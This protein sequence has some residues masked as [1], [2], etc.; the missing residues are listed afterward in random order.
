MSRALALGLVAGLAACG[1][2]DIARPEDAPVATILTPSDG[3]LVPSGS[4]LLTGRVSDP[5]DP[6]DELFAVWSVGPSVD[7]PWTDVCSGLAGADGATS[8]LADVDA[9]VEALRLLV[10]DAA[11]FQ[12][13]SRQPIVVRAT[14]PPTV[15]L[16]APM[17]ADAPFPRNLP[18]P[19]VAQVSDPD[20]SLDELDIVWS[21]SGVGP[22]DGPELPDPSGRLEGET[23]LPLGTTEVTLSVRDADGLVTRVTSVISVLTDD[24]APVVRITS[25]EAGALA[26]GRPAVLTGSVSDDTTLVGDLDVSWESDLDGPLGAADVDAEGD[27]SLDDVSLTR[28]THTLSLHAV[29]QVGQRSTATV[30]VKVDPPPVLVV[31]RP[32][33]PSST[34]PSGTSLLVDATVS[35][36]GTAPT[37]LRLRVTSDVTGTL[38]LLSVDADGEVHAALSL[39]PTTH[40]LTITAIDPDGLETSVVRTVTPEVTP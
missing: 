36:D 10:R 4:L 1:V 13:V 38:P 18:V 7:G 6:A 29:D 2:T 39:A 11:G 19:L 22:L 3:A 35:D 25:P 27:V 32:S 23:R 30:V 12:G 17:A 24:D 34:W 5:Q 31:T 20:G 33:A 16:L 14:V 26:L 8:C 28:G 15:E 37:E 9:S 40:V 21:A